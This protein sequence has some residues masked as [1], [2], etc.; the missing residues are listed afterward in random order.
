MEL[1]VSL[2]DG[3]N[4]HCVPQTSKHLRGC[5]ET[6]GHLGPFLIQVNTSHKL[7]KPLSTR[8]E[9]MLAL[10]LEGK[11]I[12]CIYLPER[13]ECMI[14]VLPVANRSQQGTER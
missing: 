7:C 6:S 5:V 11:H 2:D 3:G 4:L 13:I 14:F 1:P 9:I 8:L 10:W 12:R